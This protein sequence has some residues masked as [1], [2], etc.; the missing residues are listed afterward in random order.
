[1]VL[2]RF[3]QLKRNW[4]F[5]VNS[6]IKNILHMMRWKMEGMKNQMYSEC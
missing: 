2:S 6:V 5:R 1:M 3:M 4:H